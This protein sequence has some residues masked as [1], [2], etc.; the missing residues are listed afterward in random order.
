M[1]TAIQVKHPLGAVLGRS[2]DLETPLAYNALYFPRGYRFSTGLQGEDIRGRY[3]VLGMC[4]N[5]RD[6]IK[7]GVNEKGLVGVTNDYRGFH[8]FIKYPLEG[9]LNLSSLHYLNYALTH[10]GSVEELVEHAPAIRLALRD[11]LGQDAWCLP[12]HWMFTDDTKRCVVVEPHQGKL[13]IHENPLGVM[14]N[15]PSFLSHQRKL[16]DYLQDQGVMTLNTAKCLPAGYDPI[17]RMIRA[18]VCLVKTPPA[19]SQEEA[20][21]SFYELI[22]PMVIPRGLLQSERFSEDTFT[23]YISAYDSHEKC[24]TIQT[25][26]DKS[27]YRLNLL[28]LTA[29]TERKSFY[30]ERVF[31]SHPLI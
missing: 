15:S 20:F 16:E 8:H 7:D 11:H 6:P 22:S 5:D 27:I 9:Y 29:L 28:D 3:A 24:M 13:I 17:S 26:R 10:Y 18:Y 2:M 1:C 14:T 25:D 19:N 21:S 31:K 4:F 30:M 23:Q 12:F